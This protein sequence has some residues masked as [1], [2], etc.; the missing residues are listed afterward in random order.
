MKLII[1]CSLI[2]PALAVRPLAPSVVVSNAVQAQSPEC[3]WAIGQGQKF[4]KELMS[5]Q[6]VPGLAVA[7]GVNGKIVWS[8]GIGLADLEHRVSVSPQTRFRVGSISKLFTAT[9][10]AK[11][12]EQGLLDLDAPVQKYAPPFPR[13]DFEITTRLLAGHLAGIRHYAPAEFINRQRSSSIEDSLNVFKN[14]PLV[15]QPG[16]KYLYSTYGYTLISAVIEGASKEEY[17]TF[18]RKDVFEPLNMP[19]TVPDDNRRIIE[20]RTGFYVRGQDGQLSNESNTDNSNR[21]AAGGFLSTAEALVRF[22][23]AHLGQGF[24]K[25]ESLT[26][27]FTSQRTSDN[28]ETGVGIGW[29]I[30]KDAKGREI[31]HHGGDSVGR[32]FLVVYPNSKVIVALLANLTFARFA[33]KEASLLAD[34][35]VNPPSALLQKTQK[36][37]SPFVTASPRVAR[38]GSALCSRIF[39]LGDGSTFATASPPVVRHGSALPP[40]CYFDWAPPRAPPQVRGFAPSGLLWTLCQPKPK[41]ETFR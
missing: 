40:A 30:G 18:M 19:R 20:N 29:R 25:S 15:H 14:D 11:L 37:V 39:A 22:G 3:V 12:H 17:L 41:R 35:F 6:G 34:L 33:E 2:F 5:Q 13:K 32:A 4:L 27:I 23:S 9:A 21:R 38:H 7:V 1:L 36:T 24:L 31:Y 16:T 26:L 10:V 8:E 28:K